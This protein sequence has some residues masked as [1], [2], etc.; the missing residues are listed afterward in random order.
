MAWPLIEWP[1]PRAATVRLD[2][3][4][5]ALIT[6]ATSSAPAGLITARGLEEYKPPKSLLA[7]PVDR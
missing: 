5:A 2:D 1:L 3:W 4:Q 6:L 7:K